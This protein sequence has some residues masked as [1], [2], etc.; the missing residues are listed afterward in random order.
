MDVLSGRKNHKG[1]TVNP[2]NIFQKK[3]KW[4]KERRENYVKDARS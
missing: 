1:F 4:R 2:L 3:W